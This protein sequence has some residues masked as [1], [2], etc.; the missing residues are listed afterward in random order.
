[1]SPVWDSHASL[2]RIIRPSVRCIWDDRARNFG[3][4]AKLWTPANPC[5]FSSDSKDPPSGSSSCTGLEWGHGSR[6][7]QHPS[8]CIRGRKKRAR[9]RLVLSRWSL[10]SLTYSQTERDARARESQGRAFA[11]CRTDSKYRYLTR[12]VGCVYSYPR[13]PESAY[14]DERKWGKGP[15]SCTRPSCRPKCVTFMPLSPPMRRRVMNMPSA[16][17]VG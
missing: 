11:A 8:L 13:H 9:M 17:V 3:L 12:Q 15:M 5:S 16:R 4:P 6:T 2:T 14:M 7:V 1:M 10:I